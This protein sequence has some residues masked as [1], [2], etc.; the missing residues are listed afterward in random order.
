MAVNI[1]GDML[2]IKRFL[3]SLF[4]SFQGFA[5]YI[6]RP[7]AIVCLDGWGVIDVE[8][9]VIAVALPRLFH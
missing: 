5:R 6:F 3:R 7:K 8:T 9:H 2:V 4:H 1:V